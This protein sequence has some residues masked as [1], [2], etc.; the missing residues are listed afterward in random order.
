MIY[1]FKISF[2]FAVENSKDNALNIVISKKVIVHLIY[3]YYF[4]TQ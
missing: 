3:I 4:Q 2:Y 1:V